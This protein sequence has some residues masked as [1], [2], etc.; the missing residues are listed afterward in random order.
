M[1]KISDNVLFVHYGDNF[2]YESGLH[3]R[4]T[5]AL[6]E[7]GVTC[8]ELPGVEPNPKVDLV[9][10]G[11]E[12]CKKHTIGCILAAGGGSVIDTAKA[13]GIGAKYD[14]DVW[15][16][17]SKKAVD[18]YKRQVVCRIAQTLIFFD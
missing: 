7:A 2:T 17:Y 1:K 15:D 8:Y 10:K 6:E 5:K 3:A 13:V 12:L 11:I 14:G 18:V 4:I 9:R 16:F